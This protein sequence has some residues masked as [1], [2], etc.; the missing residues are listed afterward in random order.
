MKTHIRT[1][2]MLALL[3]LVSSASVTGLSLAPSAQA[4]LSPTTYAVSTLCSKPWA[5]HAGCLGLR[6]VA[7]TPRSVPDA[8]ALARGRSSSGGPS[9]ALE[10]KNRSQKA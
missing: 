10:L 3:A 1:T 6:L 7:K 2:T 8:R 4:T 9:P 5:G